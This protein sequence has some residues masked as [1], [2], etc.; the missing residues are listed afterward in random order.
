VLTALGLRVESASIA[1]RDN[2]NWIGL[3]K[4]P[5]HAFDE[6]ATAETKLNAARNLLAGFV[7]EE[8]FDPDFHQGSSLDEVTMSQLLAA[9]E[10][11]Q[12]GVDPKTHWDNEVWAFVVAQLRLNRPSVI[13]V[14]KRLMQQHELSAAELQELCADIIQ[15]R[16]DDRLSK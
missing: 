6:N 14:A 2:Q 4:C 1:T 3:T 13:A 11:Q 12:I 15:T 5:D 16:E 7:A 10:A 9:G 8:M